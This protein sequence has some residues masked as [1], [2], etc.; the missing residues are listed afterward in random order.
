MARAHLVG[1][2]SLLLLASA[3][4]AG[5]PAPPQAVIGAPAA[6]KAP[7]APLAVAPVAAPFA[8]LPASVRD[9]RRFANRSRTEL[10]T[11]IQGMQALFSATPAG[12]P[13]RPSTMHRLAE[14]YSELEHVAEAEVPAGGAGGPEA[15]KFFRLA[16]LTAVEFYAYLV[17]DYPKWCARP[18]PVKPTGCADESLYY[19]GLGSER[20][21]HHA[22]AYKSYVDVIRSGYES[23]FIPLAHLALGEL[24]LEDA[25]QD[26]WKLERAEQSYAAVV[27]YPPLDNPAV[28]YAEYRLGQI[29]ARRG[30]GVRAQVHLQRAATDAQSRGDAVLGAL[31]EAA[32]R[33][34]DPRGG[35]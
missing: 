18:D 2:V 32:R 8:A 30:D 35:G 1:S 22:D 27:E 13:D 25:E 12:S 11:Q 26:P 17:R 29:A 6:S 20:F 7:P 19:V 15:D 3:C 14:T 4:A 16:R 21:G 5:G 10:I 34:L 24:D 9:G 28:G 33:A 23:R 31:V